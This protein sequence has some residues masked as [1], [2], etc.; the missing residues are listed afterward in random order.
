MPL[1]LP[2]LR[3][4]G[5]WMVK[6][7]SY[8]TVWISNRLLHRE[9]AAIR[10]P[11]DRFLRTPQIEELNEENSLKRTFFGYFIAYVLSARVIAYQ[12]VSDSQDFSHKDKSLVTRHVEQVF[13][14]KSFYWKA[15]RDHSNNHNTKEFRLE[16]LLVRILVKAFW[17]AVSWQ[18]VNGSVTGQ[19][20]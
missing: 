17:L 2:G 4:V 18:P 3:M 6:V 19:L 15:P 16:V 20:S 11:S 14:V 12:T 5:I 1:S 9:L 10:L 13:L 7:L 8:Q